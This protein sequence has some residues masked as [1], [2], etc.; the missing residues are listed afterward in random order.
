MD[1][2][3]DAR[4][5]IRAELDGKGLDRNTDK[6]GGPNGVRRVDIRAELDG[7]GLDRNTDKDGGPNGVR[8]CGLRLVR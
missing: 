1:V 4:V 6:D 2:R 8:R 3:A 5:D 7:K